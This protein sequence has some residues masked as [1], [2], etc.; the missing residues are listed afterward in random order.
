DWLARV[1]A[2]VALQS[3]GHFGLCSAIQLL[4]PCVGKRARQGRTGALTS[5]CIIARVFTALVQSLHDMDRHSL[6]WPG[7][8]VIC[9]CSLQHHVF[10]KVSPAFF[11]RSVHARLE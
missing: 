3:L 9:Q 5:W 1:L 8:L 10:G 6:Y 4:G 2:P 11:P 7:L